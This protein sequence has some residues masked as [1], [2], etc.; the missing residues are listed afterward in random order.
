[1]GSPQRHRLRW[2]C[3]LC[4]SQVRAAQVTR[5]LVS[6]VAETYHLPHPCHSVFWVYNQA[7]SQ[8]DVDH[9][10]SQEVLVSHKAYLQFVSHT[11]PALAHGTCTLPAHTTQDLGCSAGNHL[12]PALGCM[13]LPV[14]SRSGSGTWVVLR[15]TDSVGHSP[16]AI[17]HPLPLPQSP[18]DCS[19]H[20]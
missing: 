16:L 13:H 6:T 4:P 9:P 20:L 17:S 19:I 12:R 15:G 18:K 5:C 10:Q 7:P 3:V 1:M 14:L 2:A 8:A 11:G